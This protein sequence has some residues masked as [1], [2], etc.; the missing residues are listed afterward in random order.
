MFD[1]LWTRRAQQ[2]QF[3]QFLLCQETQ[4]VAPDVQIRL[5]T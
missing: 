5:R 4:F 2:P 3:L 1:V